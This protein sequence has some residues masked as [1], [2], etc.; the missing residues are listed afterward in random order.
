M[1]DIY[2]F[3]H[4]LTTCPFDFL[5]ESKYTNPQKGIDTNA[6]LLDVLRDID[7]SFIA[8][9]ELQDEE[10]FKGFSSEHLC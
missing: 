3:I 4:H 10:H 8:E 5:Q 1:Y 9:I 7:S 6:L 2:F